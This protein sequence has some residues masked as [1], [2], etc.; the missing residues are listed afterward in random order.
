MSYPKSRLGK[1]FIKK[2]DLLRELD[3]VL[4]AVEADLVTTSGDGSIVNTNGD[5]R[6]GILATDAQHGN[7]GGGAL[8]ATATTM[9]PGFL[10][11]ADK[12]KLD[13]VASTTNWTVTDWY[14]DGV[15]GLDSNDGVT[16][17]TPLQTGAELLRRLGPYAIWN[18][19]VTVHVLANGMIDGLVLRGIMMVAGAHLDV[20]GTATEIAT[21]G[22]VTSYVGIDHTIA[23]APQLI[24]SSVAD[25]TNYEL[26]RIRDTN[27]IDGQAQIGWIAKANPLNNVGVPQGLNVARI[28]RMGKLSITST[29]STKGSVNPAI[30]DPIV[31]ETL[32]RVP[33]I[34]LYVDGPIDLTPGAQYPK[35]QVLV[36]HLDTQ[37]LT[38]TASG[39]TARDRCLIF[40]CRLNRTELLPLGPGEQGLREKFCCLIATDSPAHQTGLWYPHGNYQ[41]C[42]IG[43]GITYAVFRDGYGYLNIANVFQGCS[44]L[45]GSET[46]GSDI[47]IFDTV[48][49]TTVAL[50]V[51]RGL[52]NLFG[53]SG[54]GNAGIGI[55]IAN[56]NIVKIQGTMNLL[57]NVTNAR[58]YATPSIDL[59]LPQVLQPNDYAQKGV[60][61]AMVAG[62]TTV[63]VPWYDNTTQRV[64]ATHAVFA[65]TPGILSV[66]QIS[67]TQ[68]TITSS[69]NL[70]TSTVHWQIS[71]LGRNIFIST[72]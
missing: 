69:S 20:T 30:N 53:V 63:T 62:T 29:T 11:A 67:N 32:P 38:I 55:G 52:S 57:A 45:L 43:G 18:Q 1:L 24:C 25:W 35:R 2:A 4:N 47:Q 21:A 7:R 34:H 61:P 40:G 70:D 42:V 66:Q 71:P 51:A 44:I 41:Y 3:A 31:I 48:G 39:V 19:S 64:T 68:F 14:I 15:V 13:T 58:L 46:G 22:L 72:T 37:L 16:A 28:A 5:V 65:G 23:R 36:Q 54:C 9:V 6:V 60:T 26:K 17:L 50:N 56:A 49:A 59:T 8:H 33:A 12:T 10:S 27:S